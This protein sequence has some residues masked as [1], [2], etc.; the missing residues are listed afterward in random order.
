MTQV[1]FNIIF[2]S[3]IYLLVAQSYALIYTTARFFHIAHAAVIALGA[4]GSLWLSEFLP[5]GPA[6]L[7]AVGLA[8]MVGLGCELTVYRSMRNKQQPNLAF[9]IASLGIYVVLQNLV[10][11][12][13]GDELV[14]IFRPDNGGRYHWLGASFSGLQLVTMG[15]ALILVSALLLYLQFT[16]GGKSLRALSENPMLAEVYGV[17]AA[18]TLRLGFIMGSALGAAGGILYGLNTGITPT[19]GFQLLLYGVVAMIVGGVG[20]TIGMA[21]GALLLATLQ[22]LTAYLGDTRWTD[23]M[24]YTLLI[25]FLA[26]RPLGFAGRRLKKV[27]L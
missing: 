16:A 3:C 11:L 12:A 7:L 24:T 8:A 1:V 10:S 2:S 18:G 22:H 19:F 20:S 9:L 23:A 6:A 14:N 13:A 26:W 25:L 15:I 17:S 21:G 27:S 5:F 4:Y